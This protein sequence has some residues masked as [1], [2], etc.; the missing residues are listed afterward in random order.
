MKINKIYISAFGK[1]KDYTLDFKDGLNI[2]YGKNENGKSTV[3]AFIKMM[4]YGSG[5]GTSQISKNPRLKYTPWSGDRAAGRI[6]FEHNN[7]NYCL[8]RQFFKSDNTDKIQLI[9]TDTGESKTVGSAVG[10]EFFGLSAA[11]FERTVFIGQLGAIAKDEDANGE[12][13]SKLSNI[14]LTGDEDTSYQTVLT[15]LTNARLEL[16]S[17]SGKVGKYDKGKQRV[18][19]LGKELQ[20]AEESCLRKKALLGRTEE[21]KKE[22]TVLAQRYNDAKKIVDSE[23]D[24]KNRLKLEEYLKLKAELDLI[25]SENKLSDGN[26]ADETFVKK[27][28]FQLSLR[29]NALLRV[30]ERKEDIL[31]LEKEINLAENADSDSTKKQQTELEN[32]LN[33]NKS[34]ISNVE[35]DITKL[36]NT[37]SDALSSKE[38][39]S[40]KHKPFSP[41]L[42]VLGVALILCSAALFAFIKPIIP[43]AVLSFGLFVL[44]LSFII[45][46]LDEK[47]VIEAEKKITD[48]KTQIFEAKNKESE[49]NRKILTDTEIL[50]SIISAISS[51]KAMIEQRKADLNTQ[52]AKLEEENKKLSEAEAELFKI[53]SLY[54]TVYSADEVKASLP[55]IENFTTKQKSIKLKLKYIS[56]DL[57]GIS[58]QD[59]AKKLEEISDKTVVDATDFEE[60]KA[61]LDKINDNIMDLK[62][63]YSA[64][65]TELKTAFKN[66][67]HPDTIKEEI[68]KLNIRLSSQKRFCEAVNLASEVLESSFIEVRRS[69]GSVLEK[70]ALN[71]FSHLTNG[72]YGNVNISKSL[73]ITVEETNNFGTREV[74][75][76]SNGTVDQAYLSLRLALSELIK[77]DDKLPIFL[78]DVLTQYDDIRAEKA[79]EFLKEYSEDSQSILFTCHKALSE[80]GKA[81]N[82][83]TFEL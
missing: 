24:I 20:N 71:I 47:S 38:T 53:F 41:A 39:A 31:K 76:L 48:I 74:E 5:R 54:K 65:N 73:D 72:K 57:G 6:F 17:K 25:N 45:R 79:I 67:P 13:N 77:E 9:N 1:L 55:E 56:D 82:I 61:E 33:E 22:I 64:I 43:L 50:N 63:E 75:Y 42:L 32:S 16:I 8:E 12:I 81:K 28:Q 40:K 27:V 60:K 83:N 19:E 29:D 30:K 3:M 26:V 58:Y 70:N 14:A 46:P 11:A 62:S 52:K 7:I 35:S 2:V 44:I 4:F 59:A 78:D 15:R 66:I 49:L 21:I 10:A 36:E 80:I 34:K 37:L 23:N 18:D 51:D 69:Y 68:E